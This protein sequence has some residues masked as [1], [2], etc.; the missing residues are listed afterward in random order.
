MFL[1]QLSDECYK[2][3]IHRNATLHNRRAIVYGFF[4]FT[5]AAMICAR[6]PLL[7][8]GYNLYL[9][10]KSIT[11]ASLNDVIGSVCAV[12]IDT[13]RCVLWRGVGVETWS[14]CLCFACFQRVDGGATFHRYEANFQPSAEAHLFTLLTLIER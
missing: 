10:N 7:H 14:F 1:H 2:Q 11:S 4:R 9:T 6:S 3:P 5:G 13:Q 12:F 8:I